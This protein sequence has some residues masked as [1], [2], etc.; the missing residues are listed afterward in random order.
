MCNM[1]STLWA[2][3]VDVSLP[4]WQQTQFDWREA[5]TCDSTECYSRYELLIPLQAGS[6]FFFPC[7][8][9]GNRITIISR[10]GCYI[11]VR[12]SN[13]LFAKIRYPEETFNPTQISEWLFYNN[14][15]NGRRKIFFLYSRNTAKYE[16]TYLRYVVKISAK[17]VSISRI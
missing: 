7:A 4:S 13:Y 17:P 16:C 3:K 5:A 6:M 11:K 1:W 9:N 14:S 10:R 8:C 15:D 12:R 2:V